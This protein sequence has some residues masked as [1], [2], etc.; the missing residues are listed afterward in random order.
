MHPALVAQRVLETVPVEAHG[1]LALL[2]AR[3]QELDVLKFGRCGEGPAAH[4]GK[5]LWY[6]VVVSYCH[7]W[8][9]EQ[10][11]TKEPHRG[12]SA[13]HSQLPDDGWAGASSR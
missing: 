5:H 8:G 1:G 13:M 4:C 2:D 12:T 7:L 6:A 11:T 3:E 10:H 9:T